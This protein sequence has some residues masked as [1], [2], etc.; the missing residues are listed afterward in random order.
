MKRGGLL[1]SGNGLAKP[2]LSC[3]DNHSSIIDFTFSKN[4]QRLKNFRLIKCAWIYKSQTD[5]NFFSSSSVRHRFPSF[6][7]HQCGIHGMDAI[8]VHIQEYVGIYSLFTYETAYT[9]C[10]VNSW[11]NSK[12][13]VYVR[14]SRIKITLEHTSC[15]FRL[16]A[17][18]FACVAL[19][20]HSRTEE[21]G[22]QKACVY[23]RL[24]A[25]LTRF[26]PVPCR[27]RWDVRISN[28]IWE[29]CFFSFTN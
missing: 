3:F 28:C 1:L 9:H 20:V 29:L 21:S 5:N 7:S 6:A 15:N 4:F 11:Y 12:R 19:Y 18:P 25:R 14:S 10:N 22:V 27:A 24:G 17:G 13:L 26:M 16:V 2:L 23:P 8:D